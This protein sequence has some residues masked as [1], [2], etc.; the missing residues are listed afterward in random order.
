MTGVKG[1]NI[2]YKDSQNKAAGSHILFIHGLGSSSDRWLDIPDALSRYFHTV[3]VDLV[4]FGG[5]DK[6]EAMDYTIKNLAEFILEFMK[7][8]KIDD[9]RTT[10][11]GH[12]LGGYIAAEAAMQKRDMVER[13]VLVDSSGMLE[14]PTPL[15][16]EYLDAAMDPSHDKVRKVF[17]QMTAYPFAVLPVLVDL[18]VKRMKAPGAKHAF[19]SAFTDSTRNRIDMARLEQIKD[20]PALIM[21][22]SGDRVIPVEHSRLFK[23]A[24]KNSSLEIMENAGHAPFAEKPAVVCEMLHSFLSSG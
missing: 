8:V 15:L 22:G 11:V 23:Q 19:K 13:L 4:G 7:K 10:I 24:L 5:S 18:F 14:R 9:G 16:E 3:A 17:E 12:S 1:F 2:R 20:I 6:P 21:W